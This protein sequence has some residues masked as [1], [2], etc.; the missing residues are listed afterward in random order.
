MNNKHTPG[1][2]F[3]NGDNTIF[4]GSGDENYITADPFGIDVD[5]CQVMA[6]YEYDKDVLTALQ[7]LSQTEANVRLIAAA[8]D[9]FEACIAARDVLCYGGDRQVVVRLIDKAIKKAE[10]GE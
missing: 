5:I 2:W 3:S 7:D 6:Q 9:L 8:P 10:I 4:L 1:P